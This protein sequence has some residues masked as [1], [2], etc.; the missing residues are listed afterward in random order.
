MAETYY[1]VLNED[2]ISEN[3]IINKKNDRVL[4]SRIEEE[5]NKEPTVTVFTKYWYRVPITVF[6]KGIVEKFT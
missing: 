6:K 2:I 3:E 5:N 1:R 4:T